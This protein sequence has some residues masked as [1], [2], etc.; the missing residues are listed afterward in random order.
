MTGKKFALG[1]LCLVTALALLVPKVLA[2]EET[3]AWEV[4]ESSELQA[5]VAVWREDNYRSRGVYVLPAG[6]VTYLLV[7]WGEKPTGGY[8]IAIDHIERAV[9]GGISLAAVL[10]EPGPDDVVTQALTYPHQLIALETTAETIVVNFIGASWFGDELG[11]PSDNDPEIVLRVAAEAGQPVANPLVV[12]GRARVYEATFILVVEDGHYH[13]AEDV[14]TVAEGGPAWAEF[15]VAVTLHRYSSPSG[16]VIAKV[17]DAK[18]GSEREI[19]VVPVSFSAISR[20]FEDVRQHW[21]E[22]S[23]RRGVWAG[24]INGYPDGT[25][26]PEAA[27]TR[28][29][30]LKMLVAS[31]VGDDLSTSSAVE[32]P[33][34]DVRDHWVADYVRWA[35]E[36][37]WIPPGDF[38]DRLDPDEIV[39][40][41]EMAFLAALAAGLLP[42]DQEIGY[43]DSQDIDVFLFGWVAA[44][45]DAGLIRGYPDGTFRPTDGLRRSEAV[46]VI[47]RVV[48]VLAE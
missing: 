26:R 12:W 40:R 47:W 25:F 48:R 5:E 19:A 35:L 46:S 34:V 38:G 42:S 10:E 37:G 30:F 36:A 16:M 18:D 17:K 7:A 45:V 23:I 31:Q 43:H 8:S 28:A 4:V 11:K 39:T 3:V 14:I 44:T 29:E 21:A 6:E 15:A 41:Q 9:T 2:E 1:V 20:P 33:F 22:A 32:I 13:L 27:V 24:F